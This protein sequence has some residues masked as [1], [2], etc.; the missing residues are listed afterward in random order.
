M[1]LLMQNKTPHVIVCDDDAELNS[2]IRSF[3]KLDGYET[4]QAL[5]AQECI[6]KLA[7]LGDIIDAITVN[8]KIASDRSA[9]LILNVRRMNKNVKVFVLA[10]RNLSEEKTRIMDYG[11]DEFAVKPLSIESLINKVNLT[12]LEAAKSAS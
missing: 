2:F 6:D 5:S 12:L 3:F 7:E 1:I 9:M 11:A 4:H 10:D 8:G